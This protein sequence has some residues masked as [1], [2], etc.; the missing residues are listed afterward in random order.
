[1]KK[2]TTIFLITA[3]LLQ[4]TGCLTRKSDTE[5]VQT[6]GEESS[7]SS[8]NTK[9][10][11][12]NPIPADVETADVSTK[13]TAV[14]PFD[15]PYDTD[16]IEM[17]LEDYAESL[18]MVYNG[19]ITLADAK[20]VTKIQTREAVSGDALKKWCEDEID[21]ILLMA[22]VCGISANNVHFCYSITDSAKYDYEYDITIFAKY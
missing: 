15:F 1:M 16:E 22:H 8:E 5:S 13:D 10:I 3:L 19:T 18:G 21:D 11:T 9:S 12:S 7:V 20:S 17:Y 14:S 6:D 4:L 2:I